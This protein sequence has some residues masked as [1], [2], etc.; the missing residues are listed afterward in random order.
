MARLLDWY[1]KD[2]VWRCDRALVA[3]AGFLAVLFFFL[4]PTLGC[5]VCAVFKLTLRSLGGLFGMFG[6]FVGGLA[7]FKGGGV[8]VAF[9]PFALGLSL[10]F[11]GMR[12]SAEGQHDQ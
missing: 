11:A 12:T 9:L 4:F 6:E 8:S 3:L 5:F 1:E 2:L 10:P 7:G